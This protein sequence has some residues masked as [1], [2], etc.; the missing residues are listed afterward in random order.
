MVVKRQKVG[1][2]CSF[3]RGS[4]RYEEAAKLAEVLMRDEKVAVSS[5][6]HPAPDSARQG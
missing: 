2:V 1:T 3:H 4:A 6:Y 5:L